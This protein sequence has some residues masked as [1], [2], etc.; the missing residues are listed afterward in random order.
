MV[1]NWIMSVVDVMLLELDTPQ[2][3]RQ[4]NVRTA[5]YKLL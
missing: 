1:I 5:K 4:S 3:E 2:Q